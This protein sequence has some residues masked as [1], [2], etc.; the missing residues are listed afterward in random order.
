MLSTPEIL[1]RTGIK[2]AK[3]LTRWHQRGLIPPPEVRLHPGGRGKIGYWPEWVVEQCL[4]IRKLLKSRYSLDKIAEMLRS[5]S[6]REKRSAK[7]GYYRFKEVAA[8]LDRLACCRNFAML[9]TNKM[10]PMLASL[11]VRAARTLRQLDEMALQ[12]PTA[13]E[14]IGLIRDGYNPVLVHDGTNWAILPDFVAGL[15]LGRLAEE[16]I[17]CLAMPIFAE[18]VTA[19]SPICDDLPTAPTVRLVPRVIKTVADSTEEYKVHPVGLQDYEL[20]KLET[21]SAGEPA[22]ETSS[23]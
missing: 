14:A 5:G 17:P 10:G 8:D 6:G 3:T 18:V 23:K 21:S 15:A 9:V 13:E 22:K 20:S 11:G 1:E 19:F 7:G 16:A 4:R 2:N 12:E